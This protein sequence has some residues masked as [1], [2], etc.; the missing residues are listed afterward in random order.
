MVP[1]A[2][3]RTLVGRVKGASGV[4]GEPCLLSSEDSSNM[5]EPQNLLSNYD[6]PSSTLMC[7]TF[8]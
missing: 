3:R 5:L 4:G 6:V 7:F 2:P 1:L 8:L